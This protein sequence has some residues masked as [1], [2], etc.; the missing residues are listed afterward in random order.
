[1]TTFLLALH[2]LFLAVVA[3]GAIAGIGM[4]LPCPARTDDDGIWAGARSFGAGLAIAIFI[5]IGL[6]LAGLIRAWAILPLLGSLAAAGWYRGC[7]VGWPIRGWRG[8]P[9]APKVFI[10]I[11]GA[12]LSLIGVNLLIGG[13][14]PCMMQDA[15]WY[16]LSVPLQWALTGRAEAFPCV[17][18][19]NY[20]LGMESI[21]A[22]ALLFSDEILCSMLY[23]V[24]V[25]V[26]IAA[27]V[28]AARRFAGWMGGVVAAAV[29]VPLAAITAPVVPANDL[30][31]SLV[32]LIGF[33]S[34][35]KSLENERANHL[36]VGFLFGT[37]MAIK[38]VSVVFSGP[39]VL[40]WMI[41]AARQIGAKRLAAA[42]GLIGCGFALA[43]LPWAARGFI[44]SGNPVFPVLSGIFPVRPEY[45]ASLDA[46]TR[47]HGTYGI[48]PAGI[49]DAL[50]TG[51]PQK[52]AIAR[53]SMDSIFWL[54]LIAALP[55]VFSP[56]RSARFQ[57][58]VLLSFYFGFVA[59]QGS[60]DV[61]RFI[62]IGYPLAA[63]VLAMG[64]VFIADR[65][66]G[67]GK[68]A[69]LTVLIL[70]AAFNYA[71]RQA[72]VAGFHTIQWKYRPVL[73]KSAIDAFARHA[74]FG[75]NYLRNTELQAVID[76]A[77]RVFLADETHPY[78][79]KRQ[80]IWG[81]EVAGGAFQKSWSGKSPEQM[82]DDLRARRVDYVVCLSDR[83]PV[84]HEMESR[85]YLRK[86]K[87]N[88]PHAM[89]V[90]VWKLE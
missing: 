45:Q 56:R 44:Y 51:L 63:P 27:M 24:V 75:E 4:L 37:A 82:R 35:A 59:I 6:G 42:A 36:A 79:L 43:Y 34:L 74:E 29:V 33:V 10:A 65:L 15:L 54:I 88:T 7:R 23:A 76:P 13:M 9:P 26:L 46:V 73:T 41:F 20:S 8:L 53:D 48:T 38:I 19:S 60:N 40:I 83:F 58:W 68:Y 2:Y 64:F 66:R 14:C 32:L 39:I 30:A 77:A 85:K 67:R 31:A 50:L 84:F 80:C 1:M 72:L 70:A 71:K 52:L 62:S 81:D 3:T 89:H 21:Y 11:G 25:L 90:S 86:I 49:R 57:A 5:T 18:P 69:L 78:Y 61:L 17:M 55:M 12:I 87:P 16:H 47:L 22:V 28:A